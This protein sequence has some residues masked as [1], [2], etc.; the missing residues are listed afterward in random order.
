MATS[1]SV[2]LLAVDAEDAEAEAVAALDVARWLAGETTM[3]SAGLRPRRQ[4]CSSVPSAAG[5]LEA[6]GAAVVGSSERGLVVAAA[7][8]D[9]QG[10]GGEQR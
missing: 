5:K 10:A 7:A 2:D 8:R 3:S 1:A 9:Q 6:S 4:I